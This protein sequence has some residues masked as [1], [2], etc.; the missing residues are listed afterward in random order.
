LSH[1]LPERGPRELPETQGP[2]PPLERLDPVRR[3]RPCRLLV[4]VAGRRP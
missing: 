2:G 1:K 3:P 4:L